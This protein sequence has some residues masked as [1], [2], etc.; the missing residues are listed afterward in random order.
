MKREYNATILTPI[1]YIYIYIY[2]HT[3]IHTTFFVQYIWERIKNN[4]QEYTR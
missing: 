4:I 1:F 2:I 3:H